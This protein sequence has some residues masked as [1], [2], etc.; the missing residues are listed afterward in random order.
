MLIFKEKYKNNNE[1][2]SFWNNLKMG[3]DMFLK[4]SNELNVSTSENG[5]YRF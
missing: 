4:D 1:I 5:D 3:Y 2:L